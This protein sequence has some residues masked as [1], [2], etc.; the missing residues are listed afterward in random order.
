MFHFLKYFMTEYEK[1]S[2]YNYGILKQFED[3]FSL[4]EQLSKMVDPAAFVNLS[5]DDELIMTRKQVLNCIL[6]SFFNRLENYDNEYGVRN[7]AK[8]LNMNISVDASNK[9]TSY[10]DSID[11]DEYNILKLEKIKFILNYFRLLLDNSS[12]LDETIIYKKIK[13]NPDPTIYLADVELVNKDMNKIKID[14]SAFVVFANKNLG[15]KILT[16]GCCQEEIKYLL[17]PELILLK[18]L[19]IQLADNECVIVEGV[20]RYNM[21]KNYGFDLVYDGPGDL[22]KETIILI[23]SIDYSKRYNYQFTDEAK[24]RELNKAKL[25]FNSV[26]ENTIITGNWGCGA[27]NSDYN[28]KY[29]IQAKATNKKIIYCSNRVT[30]IYL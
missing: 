30:M 22:Y 23:D 14:D 8:L 11:P 18:L 9:Y 13:G 2:K 1:S 16:S 25:A 20:R 5:L 27:F 26:K 17:N 10:D 3:S 21:C 6:L 15:G 24:Q 7:F 28:L 19:N 12:L 29:Q 4:I